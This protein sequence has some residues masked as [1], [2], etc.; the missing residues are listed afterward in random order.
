MHNFIIP[1]ITEKYL[2]ISEKVG[3]KSL[4][5]L[6]PLQNCYII[7]YIWEQILISNLFERMFKYGFKQSYS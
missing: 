2:K 4:Y 1:K 3:I 6:K 5:L 7:N